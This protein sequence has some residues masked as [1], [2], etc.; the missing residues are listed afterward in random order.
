MADEPLLLKQVVA[1]I[2]ER[3]TIICLSAAGQIQPVEEPFDTLNGLFDHPPFHISCRD[4]IGPWMAGF[5]NTVRQEANAELKRRPLK[6]RQKADERYKGS[7]GPP[8]VDQNRP[9]D[10]QGRLIRRPGGTKQQP[11]VRP[12]VKPAAKPKPVKELKGKAAFDSMTDPVPTPEQEWAAR[13]YVVEG[14]RYTNEL[15]RKYKQKL[16]DPALKSKPGPYPEEVELARRLATAL[17]D[18]FEDPA[19]VLQHPMVVY[20]GCT[21]PRVLGGGV[22]P[23]GVEFVD[24]AFVS[25]SVRDTAASRFSAVLLEIHL[26]PGDRAIRPAVVGKD[27]AMERKEGEILLPSPSRFRVIAEKPKRKTQF[28]LK[29]VFV[30]EVVS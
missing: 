26:K 5:V 17:D 10:E 18:L 20:R 30:V 25:T 1:V 22:D 6:E 7:P 19:A 11:S 23:V 24:H 27:S 16:R 29:R 13:R 14:F 15:A 9:V 2:D 21:T 3:T 8:P 28:G 4:V 12:R